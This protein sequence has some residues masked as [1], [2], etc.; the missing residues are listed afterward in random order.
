MDDDDN[1]EK[2]KFPNP[3]NMVNIIFGD[4]SVPR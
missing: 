1:S 3:S 2:E 4:D